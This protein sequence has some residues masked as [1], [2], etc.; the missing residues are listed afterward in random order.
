MVGQ[1]ATV[2]LWRCGWFCLLR[3]R[4]GR[5]DRGRLSGQGLFQILDPQ[6]QRIVA[7][8][9]GAAAELVAQQACD[10]QLQPRDLGLRLQQQVL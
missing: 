8:P 1:R 4:L 3:G 6:L 7:E 2:A 9:F 10:Q 5:L